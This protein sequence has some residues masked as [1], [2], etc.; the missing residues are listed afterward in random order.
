MTPVLVACHFGAKVELDGQYDRLA[1]VLEFTARR[2]C[3]TWD[4]RITRIVP[5]LHEAASGNP[6]HGWNTAKLVFW[7]EAVE[8]AP[9]DTPMLLI[10][11]DTCILQPL[12]PIWHQPFDL[13]YTVRDHDRHRIP[14]N[15]GVV[16]VRVSP[17]VRAAMRAWRDDNDR[18]MTDRIHH[19]HWRRK[20]A[21][22]N[23]ASFGCL[24]ESGR[25]CPCAGCQA[26][27]QAPPS[28]DGLAVV[29][30]S[31]HEWNCCEWAAFRASRARVLHI[32]SKLRRA[33]FGAQTPTPVTAP[34]ATL[35]HRLEAE[36]LAAESGGCYGRTA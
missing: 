30:L 12:D 34:L 5:E 33:V 28:F 17:A 35:W 25:G 27:A 11:A 8:A 31:C 21:G 1:R 3:P 10:D 9:D 19:E 16:A 22:I 36:A 18:M 32:K 14:L 7:Q 29:K 4:L 6:S 15:G 23:Q 13:A 2:H 24:L 20:Y 26:R